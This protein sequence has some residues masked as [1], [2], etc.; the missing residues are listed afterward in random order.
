MKAQ[1]AAFGAEIG[2]GSATAVDHSASEFQ[3]QRLPTAVTA[4]LALALNAD[5]I[6][7]QARELAFTPLGGTYNRVSADAT[8][9][10]HRDDEFLLEYTV[11][12]DSAQPAASPGAATEWLGQIRE[13]LN[14]YGTGRAYQNFADPELTDPLRAYYGQNLSRLGEV[15]WHY[16]PDNFFHHAQS[17]PPTPD[18]MESKEVISNDGGSDDR[19]DG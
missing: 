2:A 4:A 3:R 8:A 10:V 7:G 9:F 15:K 12:S 17:I 13:L 18:A 6:R 19:N 16:D 14:G 5:R 1:L 11:T